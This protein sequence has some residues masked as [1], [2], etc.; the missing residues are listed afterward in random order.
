MKRPNDELENIGVSVTAGVTRD[1]TEFTSGNCSVIGPGP[2]H[3]GSTSQLTGLKG[4]AAHILVQIPQHT[5]RGLEE[6]MPRRFLQFNQTAVRA[7]A[8]G[9]SRPA[10]PCSA[11]GVVLPNG[12]CVSDVHAVSASH[13]EETDRHSRFSL[14]TATIQLK[15]VIIWLTS[16][17]LP[18]NSS[19]SG[20]K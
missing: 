18:K 14:I 11:R 6:S 19:S 5:F 16:N 8:F 3:G 17:N 15:L 12:Q 10:S 13:M 4:S 7:L 9:G 2:I 20:P 1:A